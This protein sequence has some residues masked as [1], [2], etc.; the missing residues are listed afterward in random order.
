M[1]VPRV[2]F[3]VD[4][5]SKVGTGHLRECLWFA[6]E[7]GIQSV[8]CIRE[9]AAAEELIRNYGFPV[10]VIERG[11]QNKIGERNKINSLIE[12]FKPDTIIVDMPHVTDGY[13]G[14]I[15]TQGGRLMVWNAVVNPVRADIQVTTV[16]VPLE[17]NRQFFGTRYILLRKKFVETKPREI[18]GTVKKISV[19][20]GGADPGNLTLKTLGALSKVSSNFSVDIILGGVSSFG[21]EVR[22]FLKKFSK[23]YRLYTDIRDDDLLVSLIKNSDLAVVSGG[24]TLA[25][26]MSLG[27]PCVAL[28]QNRIEE[29]KIYSS[30]PGGSFLNLGRGNKVSARRIKSE[31]EQLIHDHS[32]R[33]TISARARK[34]VDGKGIERIFAI[35]KNNGSNATNN[36]Q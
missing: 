32:L 16:F 22:V 25:E 1:K 31:V 28:S 3:R 17:K 21:E 34:V 23:P 6:K 9:H 19:M 33:K 4:A 2:L 18:S 36:A 13:L 10:C 24:Y 11:E 12:S 26:F 8:F 30:F 20:F 14:K 29:K 27:V 35:L 5:G 15:R 7:T